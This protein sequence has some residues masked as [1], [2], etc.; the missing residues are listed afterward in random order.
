MLSEYIAHVI[1]ALDKAQVMPA[2]QIRKITGLDQCD[3][4][5]IIQGDQGTRLTIQN[6]DRMVDFFGM[7]MFNAAFVKESFVSS[8]SQYKTWEG[9]D[10]EEQTLINIAGV[11]TSS[12]RTPITTLNY[13][14]DCGYFL[15]SCDNLI[16]IIKD[17]GASD[18]D[19]TESENS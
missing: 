5:M 15:E 6:V 11:Y 4:D 1:R 19:G 3:Y 7:G 12:P 8:G 18:D 10:K 2:D 9:L 17:T 14:K 16:S 13:T